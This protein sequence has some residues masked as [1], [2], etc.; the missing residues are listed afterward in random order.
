[1]KTKTRTPILVTLDLD[2]PELC[3]TL[4]CDVS[5]GKEIFSFEYADSWLESSRRFLLDPMLTL[6]QGPQYAQGANFG[7]FLDS[8]PDR[9]GRF[10][11]KRREALK[12]RQEQRSPRIL[13]E[14]DY[15]LGVHDAY[16]VGALRFQHSVDGPF[17]DNDPHFVAPPWASLREL[18]FASLGIEKDDALE[19]SDYEKWLKMLIAPGG[20][21]GGARPKAS[22]VD[23]CGALWIAKFPG[24]TDV[25]DIGAWEMVVHT[26]A[27]RARICV[28]KARI[29]R[30][31]S[32][33][34]TFMVQRFDRTSA[35]KRL[36]FMSAMTALGRTDGDDASMGVSYLHLAE[37]LQKF[38][39]QTN[40][41]LQELWSRIAFHIMISNTDDHLRN[42]GFLIDERGWRLSPAY[43]LNP[44]PESEGLKLN[45]S[46]DD[47]F[48]SEEIVL[49][50][51]KH[52]RLKQTQA[53][54]RYQEIKSAV[55]AWRAVAA[56]Y[57]LSRSSI[58]NMAPAFRL[59]HT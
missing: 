20:S 50:V 44:N 59:A 57:G 37:F 31:T 39:S 11:I 13:K 4:W 10:L 49:S 38:G 2:A 1:M 56:E 23:E 52:F 30:F 8:A 9:W 33:H 53:K 47:N 25:S 46:E 40:E 43:D 22:V 27:Q 48:Q 35:G 18:E 7:I 42:H 58:E 36:F 32:H 15:L 5:R 26:L 41:D 24:R 45:I 55:S 51:A 54:K 14:T 16:R 17:L 19:Q 3:G 21:L 29:G 28:P 34:H 12:A 6:N